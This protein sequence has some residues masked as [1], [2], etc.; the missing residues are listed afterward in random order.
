MSWTWVSQ[1]LARAL[2]LSSQPLLTCT[3]KPVLLAKLSPP[4]CPVTEVKNY[5]FDFFRL[6]LIFFLKAFFFLFEREGGKKRG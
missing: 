3:G 4:F 6:L 5:P 1:A 2:L